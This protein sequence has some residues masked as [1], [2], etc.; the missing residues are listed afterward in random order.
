MTNREKQV[1]K[2]ICDGLTYKSLAERLLIEPHMVRTHIKNIY[3]K[4]HVHSKV[5]AT[6]KAKEERIA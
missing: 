5:E 4:L 3:E 1:L 2:G 6:T